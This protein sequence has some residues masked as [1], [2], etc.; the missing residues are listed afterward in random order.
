[1]LNAERDTHMPQKCCHVFSDGLVKWRNGNWRK[2][3]EE[4][5]C[6]RRWLYTSISS[7]SWGVF[8]PFMAAKG[9]WK[10]ALWQG[11]RTTSTAGGGGCSTEAF[12]PSVFSSHRPRL[13]CQVVVADD[14]V[15]VAKSTASSSSSPPSSA[16]NNIFVTL[17]TLAAGG[18][19]PSLQ[20][21]SS[22]LKRNSSEIL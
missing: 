5:L 2:G 15:V 12:T 17:F 18:L 7:P 13:P 9:K 1:M 14:G 8:V 10:K 21:F 3:D 16:F 4:R 19:F 11:L 20:G 22:P 6:W